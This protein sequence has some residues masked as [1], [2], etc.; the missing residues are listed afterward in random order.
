[1]TGAAHL[2]HVDFPNIDF[3]NLTAKSKQTGS[4]RS[5]SFKACSLQYD[6]SS[7][8]ILISLTKKQGNFNPY[9]KWCSQLL[10]LMFLTDEISKNYFG[11]KLE[12]SN[13]KNDK[14]NLFG[15]Y[16]KMAVSK[17]YY[18]KLLAKIQSD[19]KQNYSNR[20]RRFSRSDSNLSH[21]E[22][23]QDFPKISR[24]SQKIPFSKLADLGKG[25][26][27]DKLN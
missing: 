9:K 5:G 23:V 19:L 12:F 6:L 2:R 25:L 16:I 24:P 3:F 7:A 17:T 8:F 27:K 22:S 13:R 10:T 15:F 14:N 1:M 20:V 11:N 26:I 4:L 18:K 21:F